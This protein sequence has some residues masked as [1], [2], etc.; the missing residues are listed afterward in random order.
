MSDLINFPPVILFEEDSIIYDG[1]EYKKVEENDSYLNHMDN[2]TKIIF[3]LIQI[4][5]LTKLLEDN[6]Y[7]QFLYSNLI[8]MQTELKRQL[9]HYGKTTN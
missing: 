5:N 3:A 2:K 7:Q 4:D 6:K 8:S 1:V 9:S